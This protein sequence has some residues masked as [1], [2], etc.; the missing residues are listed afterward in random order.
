MTRTLRFH[1]DVEQDVLAGYTWYETKVIIVGF[2][3]CAREPG[4]VEKFLH[5][6]EN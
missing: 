6:R 3:L 4:A 2:F 5:D 1:P